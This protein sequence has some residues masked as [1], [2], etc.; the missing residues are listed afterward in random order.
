ML[1]RLD[2]DF[3][4]YARFGFFHSGTTDFF[5]VSGYLYHRRV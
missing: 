5:G 1:V 2:H 3:N 4:R